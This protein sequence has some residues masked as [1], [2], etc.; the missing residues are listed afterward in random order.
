MTTVDAAI[1]A[2]YWAARR[3][4]ALMDHS[5][6]GRLRMSGADSLDLLHRLSTQDL[7]G[8]Q[9][10]QGAMTV[11]TSDKG[12]IIDLLTVYHCGDHLLL[13]TSPGNQQSVFQWLDKYTIIEDSTTTDVTAETALLFFFGPRA[14][15]LAQALVAG[16]TALPLLHHME[17]VLN[18]VR[19]R[20]ARAPAPAGDGFHL[21]VTRQAEVGAAQEA[22]LEIGRALGL[23]PLGP[24]VYEVLRIEA[25]IPAFGR[26]LDERYNP[27][28]AQLRSFISFDKGCYIGQEVVARLDTYSK[29]AK[30]L[31]GLRLPGGALPP[32]GARLEVEGR[33]AGFVTSVA[34]SP[35][36]E[37]PIAL[38]YVRARHAQ[39]GSR[40]TLATAAGALDV[41]VSALPLVA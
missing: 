4:V 13:L 36:L 34:H 37:R 3:G 14:L 5:D 25:G 16:S 15:E 17:I 32:A 39:P 29:V 12:R 2:G 9:A 10:G 33:E 22:L 26:E 35:A 31:V 7:R 24:E 8:L 23:Q 41:E 30:F 11:L 40:L 18:G 28:E 38:A 20:L 6:V 21:M 27:L 1:S 19:T